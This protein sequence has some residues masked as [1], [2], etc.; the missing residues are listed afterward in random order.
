MTNYEKVENYYNI[1]EKYFEYFE[2]KFYKDFDIP[3]DI[4]RDTIK[5]YL[6]QVICNQG[7]LVQLTKKRNMLFSIFLYPIVAIYFL[8]L[9]IFSKKTEKLAVDVLY[10]EWNGVGVHFEKFYREI[11]SRL[12]PK[13]QM[14]FA[15]T[16]NIDGSFKNDIKIAQRYTKNISERGISQKIFKNSF[17]NFFIL[18][19]FTIQARFDYISLYLRILRSMS[20]FET[21]SKNLKVDFLITACD[22]GYNALRYYI[23]KKNGIKNIISI[24]NGARGD[25]HPWG[26]DMYLYSDYYF[27]YGKEQTKNMRGLKAKEI[28]YSGSFP[29]YK[30]SKK[31]ENTKEEYDVILIEQMA[32][33]DIENSYK[34]SVFMQIIE[35]LKIFALKHKDL[36]IVYRVRKKRGLLEDEYFLSLDKLLK[37]SN[38]IFESQ[39]SID[40]YEAVMKSNVVLNYCS[41]LGFESIGMDKKVLTCNYD[42]LDFLPTEDSPAV[43]LESGYEE[44]EKKLLYLLEKD[45]C[46]VENIYNEFKLKYMNLD[47]NPVDKV[48][49]IVENREDMNKKT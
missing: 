23:Y 4:I 13:K 33:K 12:L 14:I 39:Q 46:E 27:S 47:G 28:I 38:I 31:Y 45:Y 26:G 41:S 29:L 15:V 3:K 22:N 10:E 25:N 42:R 49:S 2:E 36:K 11:Y 18:L 48:V 40:S 21:E 8:Y 30:L 44:F 19:R 1:N 35:N 20:K 5:G 34:L 32:T 7:K 16:K 9:S 24:Q 6:V 17:A 43:V 37:D